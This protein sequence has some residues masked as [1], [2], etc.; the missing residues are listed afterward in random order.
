MTLNEIAYNIAD[1]V[2]KSFDIGLIERIKFS[3]KYY[4]A[5]LIRQ[6]FEKNGK[7]RQ[8]L[9]QWV[10]NLVK[11]D[12]G[13]TCFANVN[14]TILKT[15]NKIPQ[16]IAIKGELFNYVG[17][18]NSANESWVLTDINAI[19]YT[20]YNNFTANVTRYFYSNGYLYVYTNKKFKFVKIEAAF[21]DPNEAV[22]ACIDSFNCLT[23]DDEFPIQ[24]HYLRRISTGLM[25]GELRM[26]TPSKEIE[27]DANS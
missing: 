17:S 15:E 24:A 1:S 9:Q 19:R 14:C 16:P 27:S 18:I 3:V 25:T 26:L 10:G 7:D 20:Q 21:V 13:D 6:D 22:S 5:E 12:E 8:V 23:D 2:G 11:V 4:R